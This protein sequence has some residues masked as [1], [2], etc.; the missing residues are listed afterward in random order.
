LAGWPPNKRVNLARRLRA[1][2]TRDAKDLGI[3]SV[4]RFYRRFYCRLRKM[5][6]LGAERPRDRQALKR[7]L[8]GSFWS[9][10][11]R[12]GRALTLPS[13]RGGEGARDTPLGRGQGEGAC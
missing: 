10:C 12:T 8:A 1:A 11:A 13:P 7:R 4:G 2:F 6:S 3:A 9:S 5:L